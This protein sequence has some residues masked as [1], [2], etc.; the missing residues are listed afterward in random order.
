[1]GRPGIG[2]LFTGIACATVLAL[3]AGA[4][5]A[6][7]PGAGNAA[8]PAVC[9][10]SAL[11]ELY[12]KRP[13]T[14][15]ISVAVTSM[16]GSFRWADAAGFADHVA[17]VP[18]SA[19]IGYR[20]ASMT[21]S[22]TAAA[23]FRLM[24]SGR[25]AIDDPIAKHL[26]GSFLE[27]L[28]K[29]GYD[30]SAIRIRHLLEHSSGLREHVDE[31]FI[32][33]L[34]ATPRRTWTPFELTKRAAEAGPPL[35]APGAEFSYSDTGYIL[36]GQIIERLKALPLPVAVAKLLNWPG[37]RITTMWW[38]GAAGA[39]PGLRAH[40]YWEGL[41]T[42]DWDPSFDLFG[43]GGIVATPAS[44]A[45]Y[46]RAL[47][48]GDIYA[49]PRTLGIQRSLGIAGA[50]IAYSGGLFTIYVG[51][52]SLIGHS[53]FWN[54]FVFASEKQGLIFAGATGEKNSLKYVELLAWLMEQVRVCTAMPQPARAHGTSSDDSR[55]RIMMSWIPSSVSRDSLR[56][57]A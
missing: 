2:L 18:A 43:G 51:E 56:T 50:P 13:D 25:L 52:Q 16:D 46:L 23:I 31:D 37:P 3:A 1:M 41:D 26:P 38:E 49:D 57:P 24:E 36:L 42:Y 19:R 53:G 29:A 20:I 9:L 30:T 17:E 32:A 45:D 8:A 47:L 40:Q 4:A 33:Q 39:R 44:A 48:S 55:Y 5:G 27:V 22:Y 15:S 12:G 14:V 28:S 35:A 10:S 11:G 34:K 21:K 7:A 54:T 6:S